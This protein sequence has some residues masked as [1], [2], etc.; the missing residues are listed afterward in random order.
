V[1]AVKR[2]HRS[3][4]GT[5]HHP[6]SRRRLLGA[7]P[8]SSTAGSGGVAPP[9]PVG[10]TPDIFERVRLAT[11]NVLHGRPLRNGR[12]LPGPA[13]GPAEGPL[14]D[15]IALLDADVLALQELDRLQERSGRVDQALVAAEAL[16]AK[17]WRY[18]AALHGRSVPGQGWALDPAEPGLRVYGPQ[19]AAVG[20]DIPSHGI[21][22]LTRLRVLC[23][24]A[25]RLVPAP[26]GLPL[27]VAGRPGL[28]MVRDQPRAALA[29][30]I[31]GEHGPFTVVAV[32]LSFVPGWNIAQLVTL[33]RWIAD[34]PRPHLVL[35]DFNMI[36]AM[37]RIVLGGADLVAGTATRPVTG[38]RPP[39]GWQSLVRAPTYPAHRPR[40]QFDHMLAAGIFPDAVS[41]A[42][43]PETP[44]SDHRPMVVEL[45]W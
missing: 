12:P 34:L 35:G 20:S 1:S 7:V 4:L 10:R 37:P 29:A 8:V 2:S 44:I 5:C 33:R 45:A 17:D 6:A 31:E 38:R 32:H 43:A 3:T 23:W 11:F 24:R 16:G 9:A 40:V 42:S 14:A 22:L 15:A 30:V 13:A 28:T 21:A 18:A 26:L 41:A 39:R 25:R 19:E 27:R 36:G